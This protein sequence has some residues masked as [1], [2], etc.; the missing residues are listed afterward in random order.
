MITHEE[1]IKELFKKTS[2][3]SSF[4]AL[5][6]YLIWQNKALDPLSTQTIESF[7]KAALKSKF[8]QEQKA[9]LAK[10][11]EQLTELISPENRSD[12]SQL[13]EWTQRA[14][15]IEVSNSN[16]L[17]DVYR[18]WGKHRTEEN[19]QKKLLFN[20]DLTQL[21]EV[22][23][24]LS[25]ELEVASLSNQFY[26]LHGALEPLC[27][28]YCINYDAELNLLNAR[29]SSFQGP[30]TSI[31]KN[32]AGQFNVIR[33]QRDWLGLTVGTQPI[34]DLSLDSQAF[35]YIT[36]L[37]SILLDP[38]HFP[39]RTNAVNIA[40]KTIKSLK[41]GLGLTSVQIDEW[42]K[43]QELIENVFDNDKELT[44]LLRECEFE[45]KKAESSWQQTNSK[46]STKSSQTQ[47]SARAEPLTDL[48]KK[49]KSLLTEKRF[50]NS[51]LEFM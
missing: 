29:F 34:S 49:E 39:T 41:N 51:E 38:Q 17:L 26:L 46:D 1:L 37:E 40:K 50:S 23:R 6:N 44:L 19:I 4:V 15:I 10:L 12:L 47:A 32:D 9:E 27:Q 43:T 24:H 21:F 8:W 36:K 20:K 2:L 14:Q 5:R 33:G 13:K 18:A 31:E 42:L 30:I 7:A 22:R 11:I 48:S 3:P 45:L 16:D 35:F 25:G 28:E